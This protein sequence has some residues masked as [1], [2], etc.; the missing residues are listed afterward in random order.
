MSFHKF[1]P[2]SSDEE[3]K[4]KKSEL[5]SFHCCPEGIEMHRRTVVA[6]ETLAEESKRQSKA[7][8]DMALETKKAMYSFNKL[9]HISSKM[10]SR[11]RSE[12]TCLKTKL[13]EGLISVSDSSSLSSST[14]YSDAYS[15]STEDVEDDIDNDARVRDTGALKQSGRFIMEWVAHPDRDRRSEIENWQYGGSSDSTNVGTLGSYRNRRG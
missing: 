10:A 3:T 6:L 9:L 15:S 13:A 1:Q 7:M 12:L 14:G 11:M 2:G 8:E 4:N 5:S